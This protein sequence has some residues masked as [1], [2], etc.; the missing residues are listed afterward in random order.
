MTQLTTRPSRMNVSATS[1]KQ[2]K[3]RIKLSQTSSATRKMEA[4][5]SRQT[6]TKLKLWPRLVPSPTTTSSAETKSTTTSQGSQ[7][8]PSSRRPRSRMPVLLSTPITLEA[9]SMLLSSSWAF[10]KRNRSQARTG[11]SS[12]AQQSLRLRQMRFKRIRRVSAN[13]K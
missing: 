3:S 13:H 1:S 7:W 5:L 6:S 8:V 4:C 12:S 11:L 9:M 10:S 2:K